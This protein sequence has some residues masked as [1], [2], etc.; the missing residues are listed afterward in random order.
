MPHP[1]T[2]LP[3]GIANNQ[4]ADLLTDDIGRL[5]TVPQIRQETITGVADGSV[6]P[7][8]GNLTLINSPGAGVR[9][10]L[11]TLQ[12]RVSVATDI[13]ITDGS[14]GAVL[15][16]WSFALAAGRQLFGTF[17]FGERGAGLVFSPDKAIVVLNSVAATLYVNGQALKTR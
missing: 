1:R 7:G 15:W 8:P 17:K 10:V 14:G 4:R 2:S 9:L 6:Q 11:L 16:A 12:M 3:T 5:V 13:Q